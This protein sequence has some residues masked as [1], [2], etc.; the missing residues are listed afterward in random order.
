[1]NT[2]RTPR[3]LPPSP[4]NG[5]AEPPID[6]RHVGHLLREKARFIACCTL[7]VMALAGVYLVL[8]RQ[9]YSSTATLVIEQQDR[10][11]VNTLLD[12]QDTTQNDL[13]TLDVI[14]TVEQ[15]LTS[16]ALELRV[17][18][19]NALATNPHFVHPRPDKPYSDDELLLKFSKW[20]TVKLRRGTRL[21]DVTAESDSPLLA[22]QIAQSLVDEYLHAGSER[23]ADVSKSADDYLTGEVTQIKAKLEKSERDLQTYRE[24]NNALSL[25]DK[26]N[27][28]VETLKDLNLKLN[29]ARTERMR[30]EADD[31]QYRTLAAWGPL[32]LLALAEVANA[33]AVIDAQRRVADQQQQ[34]AQLTRRYRFAHP[35]YLQAQNQLAQVQD[36]LARAL[37]KSGDTIPVAYHAAQA[38]EEKLQ[39]A[40]RE[41]E[42]VASSLNQIAIPYNALTREVESNRAMYQ[43]V[44]NRLKQN[45]VTQALSVNPVQIA[46]PARITTEPVRPKKLLILAAGM[47]LGLFGGIAWCLARDAASPSLRTVDEAENALGLA[48]MCAVPRVAAGKGARET[49]GLVMVRQPASLAA[50]AF[51]SLRTVLGVHETGGQQRI[52]FTSAVP[53]EG[54]TFCSVNCA[55]ALAQQGYRTLLVDA[56]LRRP[57]LAGIFER[58]ALTSG[59]SDYLAG[60][61]SLAEAIG[62]TGIEN[63]SLLAAGT[64]LPNPAE[65]LTNARLA[66]LVRDPWFATFDRVVFDTAPVNAVS[67]ALPLV[68]HAS[69][70]CLV[71][72]A[73]VT[74]VKACRRA[75]ATLGTGGAAEVGVVLNALPERGGA[76]FFYHYAVPYAAAG[77]DGAA[78]P[79]KR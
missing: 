59:F 65:L 76:D 39:A 58:D 21:I 40:L 78:K 11:T 75:H 46:Q 54:K 69:A 45:T 16:D 18:Q 71:V 26:Q 23:A 32:A 35:K 77:V 29:A 70:L 38:N 49:R 73:G 55:V 13:H 30:L 4:P 64:P 60:R 79:S 74:P 50:E 72:R 3:S 8:A 10:K 31:A 6:F 19:A 27:I 41:Q 22:K 42:Q 34:F 15:S 66:E 47:I 28:V 20:V 51:R 5:A 57:S 12:S 17:I 25:E 2:K 44:L 36:D 56:D 7:G 62:T 9:I 48:V 61:A 33:P 14:K 68:K 43:S 24:Q 63:L 1:M 52:V 53:G 67:D 37:V